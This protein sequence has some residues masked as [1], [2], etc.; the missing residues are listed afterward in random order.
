[1]EVKLPCRSV[2]INVVGMPSDTDEVNARPSPCNDVQET[3]RTGCHQPLLLT[4]SVKHLQASNGDKKPVKLINSETA[5]FVDE[6][7]KLSPCCRYRKAAMVGSVSVGFIMIITF[8]VLYWN[9]HETVHRRLTKKHGYIL[10]HW[11]KGS[12]SMAETAVLDM[13]VEILK[14]QEKNTKF[15]KQ[16]NQPAESFDYL[17]DLLFIDGRSYN[18]YDPFPS[19]TTVPP[20]RVD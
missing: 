8:L 5:A 13:E 3:I 19:A 6:V 14:E 9:Y 10:D 18:S 1:M 2:S 12:P 7:E 11:G 16:P 15:S 17:D 20:S 4:A